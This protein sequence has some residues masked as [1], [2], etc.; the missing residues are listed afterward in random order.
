[1][2]DGS[3][4]LTD[5]A[6]RVLI[7][8]DHPLYRAALQTILP[9][10]C[11][12]AQV[13]E[14][15]CQDEVMN[16][17]ASDSDF[18]LI[19]LDLNL[20]GATGLSCLRYVHDAAPL[21]PI[22][23]VSGNDDPATMSEA[24]LAGAAGYVPKSAPGDVLVQAIRLV[25]AG[26]TYLPAAAALRHSM[27]LGSPTADPIGEPLT[28]RQMRVLRLLTQGLS[29]KQI[30]RDLEISEITVKAHVSAIF[31]KLGV[32][33]RTQAANAARRLLND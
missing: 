27:S 12:G 22:I 3:A 5:Q 9:R 10:A 8:D 4:M 21:T 33:N 24:R 18:D 1:M 19:V 13:A 31:R 14:A 6:K 25:M 30:A 15:A 29:N 20:P 16:Q 28:S 7:A 32:S 11:S 17:V 26:G 2:T 23:V